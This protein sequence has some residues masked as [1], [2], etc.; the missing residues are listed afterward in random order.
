MAATVLF[1]IGGKAITLGHVLSAGSTL[2]SAASAANQYN[3]QIRTA[4]YNAA[5]AQ[6]DSQL[7]SRRRTAEGQRQV[8]TIRAARAK[9]GV[10]MQGSPL[11]VAAHSLAQVELDAMNARIT[12][13][14]EANLYKQQARSYQKAKPF[15]VGTSLLRGAASFAKTG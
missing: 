14:H 12:G 2:L 10:T 9:S 8:A 3:A 15:G 6:Q 13:A 1:G 7:E 5:I 11:L 4:K